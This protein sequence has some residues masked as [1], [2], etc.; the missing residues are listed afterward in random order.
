ML[1]VVI[2][3]AC[4]FFLLHL[5]RDFQA[6]RVEP[7]EAGGVVLVVG[8]RRVGFHRG[9]VRVVE[10]HGNLR[11]A[12]MVLPFVVQNISRPA[13]WRCVNDLQSGNSLKFLNIERSDFVAER[14]SRGSN[15]QIVWANHLPAR[16]KLCPNSSVNTR[17]CE[18][19]MLDGKRGEDLF[20]VPLSAN[21]AGGVLRA[22]DTVEEFGRASCRERVSLT[23]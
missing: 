5:R 6:E 1:C 3:H 19:E 15:L 21:L 7:D 20:H 23:V 17:L 8:A 22:L 12:T 11:P 13:K 4:L 18:I 10:A 14:Q 9:D 16:L 2:T